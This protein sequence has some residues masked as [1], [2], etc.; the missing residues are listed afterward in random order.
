MTW[1]V[2]RVAG[3]QGVIETS[4]LD[5]SERVV[6]LAGDR[7]QQKPRAIAVDPVNR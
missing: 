5:G 2:R 6:L 3:I 7:R 1:C 4:Q